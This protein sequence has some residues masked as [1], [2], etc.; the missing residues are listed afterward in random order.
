MHS[1]QTEGARNYY[2]S[3]GAFPALKGGI[4][5]QN[6]LRRNRIATLWSQA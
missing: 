1:T 5:S 3:I 2:D 6:Q 4:D